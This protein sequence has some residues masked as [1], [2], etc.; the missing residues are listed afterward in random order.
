CSNY[1]EGPW[2]YYS[3]TDSL[4]S[5]YPNDSPDGPWGLISGKEKVPVRQEEICW[6][7]ANS[8]HNNSTVDA[9]GRIHTPALWA[10]Y[11]ENYFYPNLQFLK[12]FVFDPTTQQFHIYEISPKKSPEDNFNVCVQPWDMEPPFGVTDHWTL[13]DGVWYPD[14]Y[15]DWNFCLY[16]DL[17]EEGTLFFNYNNLKI[18][19][20]DNNG[21]MVVLWQ[22]SWRARQFNVYGDTNY[23]A[24]AETPEIKIAFTSGDG[25][26]TEPV[27][28]NNVEN[29]EMNSIVPMWA[30]PADKVV[31]AGYYNGNLYA[32][33][34]LMFYDDYFWLANCISPAAV[35][36]L[37]GNVMFAEVSLIIPMENEDNVQ[38]PIAKILQGLYPNP[39]SETVALSLNLD[40]RQRVC[41]EIYNCKGQKVKT[42]FNG[43]AEK[44]E[45]EISW[46]GLDSNNRKVANGLYFCK[47]KTKDRCETAKL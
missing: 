23:A 40:K 13:I 17:Y 18:T 14:M 38:V 3:A 45:T 26:W 46:N 2:T 16:D 1:G 30:Y 27:S 25:N 36:N 9:S 11:S 4:P 24:F 39:F 6:R 41:L 35:P 34:G 43:Y 33:L 42:I 19:E 12:E 10:L 29:P 8:G 22:N 7:I 15:T 37:G 5:W 21:Y 32:N 20:P 47:L 28:I 31:Q 44:G